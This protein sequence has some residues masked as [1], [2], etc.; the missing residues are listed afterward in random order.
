MGK[1]ESE[2]ESLIIN[3]NHSILEALVKIDKN[4]LQV[5]FVVD[6][7]CRLVGSLSDGDIRRSLIKSC[8]LERVVKEA[9]NTDPVFIDSEFP[10]W[11]IRSFMNEK[12]IKQLPIV[13]NFKKVIDVKIY[14]LFIPDQIDNEVVLIAGGLGSRLGD[15]TR[16]TPK[17]M[18]PIGEKPIIEHIINSFKQQGFSKFNLCLNYKAQAFKEHFGNGERFDIEINYTIEKYKMGTAGALRLIPRPINPFIVING[19][20]LTNF[21]YGRILDFH[22]KMESK[23]TMFVREYQTQVPYGVINESK[24]K[25]ISIEEKPRFSHFINTGVYCL[26]PEAIDLI[27]ENKPFDMVSLFNSL[28]E[29]DH[30]TA[31]CPTDRFWLDIGRVQD[32]EKATQEYG[33]LWGY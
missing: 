27:P 2:F 22:N 11:Q 20:L 15:L 1:T 14:D 9:M 5:I 16:D 17:P 29:R 28:I 4:G 24:G 19:D 31:L 13:D 32:Y 18:L 25:I 12:K 3:Q 23:A 6:D 26:S 33:N 7:E 10:S 21:E 30:V 8:S